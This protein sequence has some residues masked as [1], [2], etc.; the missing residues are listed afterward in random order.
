MRGCQ[1]LPSPVRSQI[2]RAT[3][4]NQS[5]TYT[6]CSREIKGII[7]KLGP[8]QLALSTSE[9]LIVK[10]VRTIEKRD[11]ERLVRSES[12]REPTVS[13]KKPTKRKVPYSPK[14]DP[15]ARAMA[16]DDAYY[17]RL[18]RREQLE[19]DQS[20]PPESNDLGSTPDKQ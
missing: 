18:E 12:V 2:T 5:H 4:A 20:L 15:V 11:P 19:R 6:S 17:K 14:R 7:V 3:R 10:R 8:K 13:L 1:Q 9:G 16:R